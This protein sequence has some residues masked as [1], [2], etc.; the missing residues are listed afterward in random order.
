VSEI[1]P[2]ADIDND[3]HV[4]TWSGIARELTKRR[5]LCVAANL[6]LNAVRKELDRANAEIVRLRTDLIDLQQLMRSK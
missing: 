2:T 6:E 3:L 1:K 4:L 5:Q